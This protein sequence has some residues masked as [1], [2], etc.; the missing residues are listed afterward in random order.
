MGPRH[1]GLDI[2][3]TRAW[4]ARFT[5]AEDAVRLAVETATTPKPAEVE[6]AE[7]AREQGI[8]ELILAFDKEI[9][10]SEEAE[11]PVVTPVLGRAGAAVA[12]SDFMVVVEEMS[13]QFASDPQA[14]VIG[15]SRG[16]STAAVSHPKAAVAAVNS[17]DWEAIVEPGV[18]LA[19][20]LNR[21]SEGL[22]EFC[23]LCRQLEPNCPRLH[24]AISLRRSHKRNTTWSNRESCLLSS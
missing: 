8:E 7:P 3:S 19:Q 18:L 24:T 20:V 12:D 13:S 5:F 23:A 6:S 10:R 1:T 2:D 14:D 22:S 11:A 15:R 16:A 4:D 9:A 21:E 17:A